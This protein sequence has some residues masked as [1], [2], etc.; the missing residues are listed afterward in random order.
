MKSSPD[1]DRIAIYA[2]VI[3]FKIIGII[4]DNKYISGSVDLFTIFLLLMLIY[5]ELKIT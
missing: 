4:Y 3:I 5:E 2:F 1:H